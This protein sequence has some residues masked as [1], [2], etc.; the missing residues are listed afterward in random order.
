MRQGFKIDL[1]IGNKDN[2]YY[3]LGMD[4][5]VDN[6]SQFKVEYWKEG[7]ALN[8]LALKEWLSFANLVN[9]YY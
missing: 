6:F 5:K 8:Y 3:R 9:R 1:K 7:N 2:A 4:P